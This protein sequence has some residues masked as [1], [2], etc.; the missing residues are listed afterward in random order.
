LPLDAI[1]GFQGMVMPYGEMETWEHGLLT[2]LGDLSKATVGQGGVVGKLVV[3]EVRK[4]IIE[5]KEKGKG[6]DM[7]MVVRVEDVVAVGREL[8]RRALE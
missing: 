2:T 4:R 3:E 5:G 7:A 1:L 8:Y 6:G